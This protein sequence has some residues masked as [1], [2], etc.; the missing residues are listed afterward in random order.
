MTQQA[1]KPTLVSLGGKKQKQSNTD[2]VFDNLL[3]VEGIPSDKI[4]QLLD[5]LARLDEV[6]EASQRSVK[7]SESYHMQ[8]VSVVQTVKSQSEEVRSL[9]LDAIDNNARFEKTVIR[10]FDE[11]ETK[12]R[13]STFT[14]M[15]AGAL[16][17]LVMGLFISA[18]TAKSYDSP[19]KT[20]QTEAHK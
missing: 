11:V 19:S 17:A 15:V 10:K 4:S 7:V 2:K 16:S 3:G 14:C 20:I 8:T 6:F 18:V 12:H 9:L 1:T 5:A 13:S